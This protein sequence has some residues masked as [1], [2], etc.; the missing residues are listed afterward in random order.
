MNDALARYVEALLA[1]NAKVNLTAAASPGAA[2]EILVEPSL[3]IGEAWDRPEPPA[4]A[5]DIGSGNGFP[6]VAVAT[7]WPDCQVSLV[8]RRQKKARAIQDCLAAAGIANASAIGCD[9]RELKNERP[10][11]MGAADLVTLRAVTSLEE[12]NR[13]AAP[14]LAPGGWVVHWKRVG[15]RAS[16]GPA[17]DRAAEGLG[18]EAVRD[19]PHG[20]DGLLV[21]YRRP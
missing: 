1:R 6:G 18:L 2:R 5:V 17:G 12:G 15:M 13:L 8:E 19:V 9:A 10:R 21:I 11:L 20:L 16:E 14:L 3:V 7:L 4:V